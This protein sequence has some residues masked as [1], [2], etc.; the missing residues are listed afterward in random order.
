[1]ARVGRF[2]SNGVCPRA[3]WSLPPCWGP[4]VLGS[5]SL[6]T[7]GLYHTQ[8][9]SL[10][11]QEAAV[12]ATQCQMHGTWR[13]CWLP[14]DLLGKTIPAHPAV[15]RAVSWLGVAQG[16]SLWQRWKQALAQTPFHR[17]ICTSVCIFLSW[18]QGCSRN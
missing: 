9:S 13:Q 14:G 7:E 12:F 5:L 18:E 3:V 11:P 6:C 1:M 4:I 15:G 2:C 10:A 8:S 16:I 17:G